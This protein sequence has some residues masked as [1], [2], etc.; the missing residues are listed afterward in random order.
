MEKTEE[1]IP[2]ERLKIQEKILFYEDFM[3]FQDELADNG[4]AIL[5][6]KVRMMPSGFFC[7]LRFFLRV[8]G[9]FFKS[10]DHRFYHQF[11]KD[12]VLREFSLLSNTFKELE[13]QKKLPFDKA[14]FADQNVM[15]PLLQIRENY[16]DKI[17][18]K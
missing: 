15:V 11:G 16:T 10:V 17:Y 5:S 7:L 14:K 12:Y 4:D 2:Y 8:D 1:K 3:L 6:A 9:V 18:I 13:E